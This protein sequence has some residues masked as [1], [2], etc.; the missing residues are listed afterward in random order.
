MKSM[1]I[2]SYLNPY[3]FFWGG[4]KGGRVIIKN[5]FSNKSDIVFQ[6]IF[7]ASLEGKKRGFSC[8]I[9]L[10]IVKVKGGGTSLPST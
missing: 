1:E 8:L 6:F 9:E 3:S 7:S 2:L 10:K 4:G 5:Y